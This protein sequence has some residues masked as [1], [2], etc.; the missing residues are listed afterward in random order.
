MTR[1]FYRYEPPPPAKFWKLEQAAKKM[2]KGLT[3]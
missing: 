1:Y 3:K 2:L